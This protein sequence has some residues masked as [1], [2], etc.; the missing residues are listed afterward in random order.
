MADEAAVRDAVAYLASS[1]TRIAKLWFIPA[2]DRGTE[3]V[4]S[5]VQLAGSEVHSRGMRLA[6]HATGLVQAKEAVRAGADLLV[7][8]VTDQE[9][10]DEFIELALRQGTILTPTLTVYEGYVDAYAGVLREDRYPLDC[11]GPHSLGRARET[12]RLHPDG[13]DPARVERIRKRSSRALSTGSSNLLRLHRAGIPIAM[14]TDAGNPLTLHGPSVH[15][16]M[17][18]MQEAGLS[19]MSVL[20]AATRDAARAMGREDDLGTVEA[21]KIADLVVVEGDP[22]LDTRNLRRLTRVI[23]AGVVHL[24]ADLL[25]PATAP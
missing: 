18:A 17:L 4:S 21:G 9:V 16:E 12:A 1:N 7:H 23:R 13:A 3:L 14:G 22:T 25:P 6:V 20:V 8:S 2:A 19:P 11:V 5:L 15:A 24:H 10:D